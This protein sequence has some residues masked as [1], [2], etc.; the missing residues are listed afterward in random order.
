MELVKFSFL[1]SDWMKINLHVQEKLFLIECG[2]GEQN[3]SW[4]ANV[5]ISRY[6][7]NFGLELGKPK[8]VQDEN[9]QILSGIIKDVLK[10][11]Q[12]VWILLKEDEPRKIKI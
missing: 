7:S 10:D 4:L 1:Y 2:K 3:I 8:G 5:G 9:G 6:D 12:H 11:L